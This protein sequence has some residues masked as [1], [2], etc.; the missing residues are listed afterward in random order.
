MFSLCSDVF[1]GKRFDAKYSI[2]TTGM[3]LGVMV[4]CAINGKGELCLKRCPPRVDAVA[5][6]GILQSAMGFIRPKAT[7][8]CSYF[9]QDGASVHTATST[10]KWLHQNGVKLLNGGCW[11]P[12]SPDLNPVEHIWPLV[13][14]QLEQTVLSSTDH[15]WSALQAAF[16]TITKEQILNLYGTMQRRLASVI[17]ANGSHTKY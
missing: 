17:V 9:Q 7:T 6:Q 10:M 12:N 3:S 2:P 15:L 14:R 16:A 1:S 13:S 11:P 4:W 5:Y 8:R